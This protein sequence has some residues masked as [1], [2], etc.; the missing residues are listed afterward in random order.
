M[1]KN[2]NSE[3]DFDTL[4]FE[5][6]TED[7]QVIINGYTGKG[8]E[9]VIPE[10][11]G[12]NPV[13]IIGNDVFSRRAD[14]TSVSMPKSVAVIGRSA[15]SGCTA[16]ASVNISENAAVIG[17]WAFHGCTALTSINI[18]ESVTVIGKSAFGGC[19]ALA[20]VSISAGLT[21][22]GNWVFS[23]CTALTSINIPESVT[24]INWAAFY[25]CSALTSLSIGDSVTHIGTWGFRGCESLTTLNIGA[26][27]A[28]MEDWAFGNCTALTA[29]NVDANNQHYA[30]RDGVLFNKTYTELLMYPAGRQGQCAIP[31]SVTVIAEKAF[32]DCIG[33]AA[34]QVDENNQQ[35]ASRDGV[36]FNKAETELVKY[37]AALSASQYDVPKSVAVI[38]CNAFEGCAAL[39]AIR[40]SDGVTAIREWA[41]R[42]CTALTSID[43][44]ESVTVIESGAF[45]DCTALADVIINESVTHT[46]DNAFYG[47]TALISELSGFMVTLVGGRAIISGYTGRGSV[48]RIPETIEGKPVVEIASYA[49]S[50]CFGLTSVN[51]GA[52]VTRIGAAFSEC[53]DLTA[54]QV[55]ANNP[56]YSSRDGVLFNKPCT[57]LVKYPEGRK[58]ECVVPESVTVI[59]NDAF[60]GCT[61]L[62]AIH[63]DENNPRY[64]SRDG[65]L[66]NKTGTTLV[67]YP[68]RRKGEY[69]IPAGVVNLANDAFS[70]CTTLTA[71]TIS[72]SGI[73]I[74][75]GLHTFSGCTGLTSV[76]IPKGITLLE[77]N[78]FSDCTALSSLIIPESVTDIVDA[79]FIGCT[80][81]TSITIGANVRM[82]DAF[83][84]DFSGFYNANG[85]KAGT[86][87]YRNS[88][89]SYAAATPLARCAR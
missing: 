6:L 16:L 67:K 9:V 34:I 87:T 65:V 76:N 23:N 29:I 14:I 84:T 1:K 5:V 38:G 85:R 47:C 63:V 48:A 15:F 3:K 25:L 36:L 31:A 21:E 68:A 7:G 77:G 59:R 39:T 62:T 58:G 81:L 88:S 18:P 45:S 30:S 17:D 53:A 86:Y 51:I 55:D 83:E 52:S 71:I 37:P 27:L 50:G 8:G 42:D 75:L 13:T 12:G 46:A 26:G 82:D 49:F 19:T 44:S 32:E 78:T 64:S 69:A 4:D 10:T 54:I 72:E 57:E 24:R 74:D 61:A 41:F 60:S 11:I 73:D 43:I 80:A 2:S 20:S 79:P 28:H 89:W 40:I 22:I 35:Y 56:A 66:F 70:G 33:L